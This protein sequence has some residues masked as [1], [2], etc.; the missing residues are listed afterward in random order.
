MNEYSITGPYNTSIVMQSFQGLHYLHG[1]PIRCHG[2]L[3][4]SNCVVDNRWLLKIT[5]YGLPHLLTTKDDDIND[6]QKYR[7]TYCTRSSYSAARPSVSSVAIVALWIFGINGRV[8]LT[9]MNEITTE[10]RFDRSVTRSP[11]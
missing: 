11:V 6:D 7:S 4:S 5:D 8:A 3:K 9:L 2:R 10:R 1:S